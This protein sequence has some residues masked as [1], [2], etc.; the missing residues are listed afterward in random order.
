MDASIFEPGTLIRQRKERLVEWMPNKGNKTNLVAAAM[1]GE[2]LQKNLA[3]GTQ[4]PS[5]RQLAKTLGVSYLTAREGVSQLAKEG[6]V[7]FR[8]GSGTYVARAIRPTTITVIHDAMYNVRETYLYNLLPAF[9]KVLEAQGLRMEI[10]STC[11]GGGERE[12]HAGII[13]RWQRGELKGLLIVSRYPAR[14]ILDFI[15]SGIPFVWINN[16]L[17]KEPVC[18]VVIDAESA[19]FSSLPLFRNATEP[20]PDIHVIGSRNSTQDWERQ[21]RHIAA[22][23][24]WPQERLYAHFFTNVDEMKMRV[25][26][27]FDDLKF[28]CGLYLLGE[29][30]IP[31]VFDEIQHRKLRAPCDVR[32]VVEYL[33]TSPALYPLPPTGWEWPFEQAAERA[34]ELLDQT[35]KHRPEEP[36]IEYIMPTLREGRTALQPP[37]SL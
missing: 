23:G 31:A 19:F 37:K 26:R 14:Q 24:A 22:T 11:H 28:P 36:L 32:M 12:E 29:A 6:I 10:C 27:L 5:T 33:S 1:T 8:H 16:T 21:F 17:G 35:A 3:V 2:I 30:A 34:L 15:A 7:E 18:S 4:L 13:N 9:R 20:A 25:R